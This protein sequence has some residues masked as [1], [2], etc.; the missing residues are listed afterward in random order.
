MKRDLE[1]L[2]REARVREQDELAR[3]QMLSDES[4]NSSA[5]RKRD[6]VDTFEARWQGYL[7]NWEEMGIESLRG[8][9]VTVPDFNV[10]GPSSPIQP[11]V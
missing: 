8:R 2:R 7:K 6:K 3:S 1:T 9:A 10:V 4:A 11:F 5:A